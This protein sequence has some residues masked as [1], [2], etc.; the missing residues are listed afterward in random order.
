MRVSAFYDRTAHVFVALNGIENL[1]AARHNVNHFFSLI[2]YCSV[3]SI[4]EEPLLVD[5]VIT[6]LGIVRPCQT[7]EINVTFK[8]LKL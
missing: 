4:P 3:S 8:E 6:Q 1:F 2:T 5:S 7:K